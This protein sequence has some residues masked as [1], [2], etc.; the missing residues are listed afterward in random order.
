[1]GGAARDDLP[2]LSAMDQ[3]TPSSREGLVPVHV[4]LSC[5]V[6]GLRLPQRSLRGIK[7]PLGG[8]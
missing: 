1:M 4:I 6:I 3:M 5:Q 7:F 2:H 8:N